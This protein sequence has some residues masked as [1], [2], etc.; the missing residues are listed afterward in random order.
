MLPLGMAVIGGF[1]CY[2]LQL[3]DDYYGNARTFIPLLEEKVEALPPDFWKNVFTIH[4]EPGNGRR[5]VL[6]LVILL[7][8]GIDGTIGEGF[9]VLGALCGG[10]F[11]GTWTWMVLQDLKTPTWRWVVWGIGCTTPLM[12]CFMGHIETYAPVFLLTLWWGML[13]LSGG[14][15][16]Y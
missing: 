13:L 3:A 11:V 12:L 2:S 8:Y 16:Y 1:L 9:R 7:T 14:G 15:C 6:Q 10:A 4:L 5:G